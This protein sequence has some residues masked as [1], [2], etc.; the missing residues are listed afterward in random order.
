LRT[1]VQELLS[2][3]HSAVT[4]GGKEMTKLLAASAKTLKINK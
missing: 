1:S 3:R 4:D 2:L